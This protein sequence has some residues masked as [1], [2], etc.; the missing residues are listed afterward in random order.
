M[1]FS[2]Q[3]YWS[4]LPFPSPGDLPNS[5]IESTSPALQADSLLS[6]PPGKPHFCLM[7]SHSKEPGQPP[8][9]LNLL[10]L[11]YQPP[12]FT[13]L[14]ST[15]LFCFLLFLSTPLALIIS[16]HRFYF[17]KPWEKVLRWV[18]LP[19]TRNSQKKRRFL[20]HLEFLSPFPSSRHGQETTSYTGPTLWLYLSLEKSLSGEDWGSINENAHL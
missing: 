11:P 5:G 10:H 20:T 4:G 16:L 2:R 18:H 7:L 17:S 13:F 12:F 14:V 1:E 8:L 9:P 15:L 19:S 3:E 6:E